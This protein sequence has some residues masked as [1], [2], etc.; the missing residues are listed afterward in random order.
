MEC[1]SRLAN[2]SRTQQRRRVFHLVSAVPS[3]TNV[4]FFGTPEFAVPTLLGLLESS[5]INLQLVVTQ[6]DRPTGRKSSP[7]FTAVKAAAVNHKIPYIL[8]PSQID[9]DFLTILVA[10]NIEAIV[11]IASGH[12]L[13]KILCEHY[14]DRIVNLH[15]SLLPRHRG[16]SPISAALL[17]GDSETG[18]SLMQVVHKLDSG[19]VL[20]QEALKISETDTTESLSFSLSLLARDLL[21]DNLE[22]WLAN[23]IRPRPQNMNNVTYAKKILPTDARINW[24]ESSTQIAKSVRA[25]IPWPIAYTEY[26]GERF[27]VHESYALPDFPST[28]IPGSVTRLPDNGVAVQCGTGALQLNLIQKEGRKLM[29][30]VDFLNGNS[31]FIGSILH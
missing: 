5:K 29:S 2:L 25:Y 27:R 19:P 23:E 10:Q 15:A 9:D 14:G 13:P 31:D 20:V 22:S 1:C 30:V 4:A 6:P 11:V 26:Q 18:V 24:N 21:L 17:S 8:Q 28:S 3:P 12:I 16:A 7:S